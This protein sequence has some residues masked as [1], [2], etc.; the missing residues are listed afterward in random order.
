[1][2]AFH[3]ADLTGLLGREDPSKR[4]DPITTCLCVYGLALGLFV[5]EAEAWL[6]II[7]S[8]NELLEAFDF[9]DPLGMSS[10]VTFTFMYPFTK[11]I[12]LL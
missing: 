1:M 5:W 8:E 6:G 10:G 11:L 4:G 12:N 7:C 2:C 9:L 3:A